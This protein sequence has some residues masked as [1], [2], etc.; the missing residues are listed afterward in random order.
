AAG[1]FIRAWGKKGSG[2]GE[3]VGLGGI[4]VAEDGTVFVTDAHNG[5]VQYFSPEGVF[6]GEWG[7]YNTERVP[8]EF[9][10]PIGIDIAPDGTVYVAD[11]GN[12]RVQYFRRKE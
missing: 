10:N 8:G 3:F 11:F 5:R 4:A 6:L 7:K 1:S 12:H 9:A 2:E